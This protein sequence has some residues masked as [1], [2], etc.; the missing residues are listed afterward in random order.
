MASPA[1]PKSGAPEACRAAIITSWRAATRGR[2]VHRRTRAAWLADA[3]ADVAR[4]RRADQRAHLTLFA[5][6]VH[7]AAD[8]RTLESHPGY[9]RIEALTGLPHRTVQR[10]RHWFERR[11]RLVC[12]EPGST[13]RYP[14]QLYRRHALDAGTVNLARTW[15]LVIPAP[16]DD[17]DPAPEP[18]SGAPWFPPS[19][20]K[21]SGPA[22]EAAAEVTGPGE[23]DGR[24]AP[25]SL[26]PPPHPVPWVPPWPPEQ[27]PHRRREMLAAGETLRG[28]NSTLARLPARH[29]RSICRPWFAAGWTPRQILAAVESAPS[30]DPHLYAGRVRIPAAWL[31]ARLAPWVGPDGHPIPPARRIPVPPPPPPARADP[32]AADAA[33]RAGAAA[34]RAALGWAAP[35]PA[36]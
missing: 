3:L 15:L 13:P 10:C 18:R 29:L 20:G 17:Q 6:A 23:S 7:E 22:R 1:R 24:C 19:A 25:G 16:G 2:Q 8:A 12:T 28:L 30:G 21:P 4:V 14:H 33:A 34:I 31:A 27:N 35:A 11:G 36:Y 5:R 9:A 26:P 32:G